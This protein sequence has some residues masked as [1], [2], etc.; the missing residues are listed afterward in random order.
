LAAGVLLLLFNLQ[1]LVAYEPTAQ[2]VVAG[3]LAV[4]G[5]G[6]LVS[7]AWRRDEW[8]RL[9]PGWTLLALA[10]M[11]LLS[12]QAQLPRPLVAAVLFVG[13]GLAFLHIYLVRR[14]EHWWAII[15]GGFMIVLAA[16]ISLSVRIARLETLGAA[17]F[18]G[19]GV[20]F[21]VLYALAGARRHW[22]AL[23]PGGVLMLFGLLIYTIDNTVQGTVLRW[24]PVALIVLGLLLVYLALTREPVQPAKFSTNVAPKG[25]MSPGRGQLGEYSGPAPGASVEVLPDPDEPQR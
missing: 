21:F 25:A 10:A 4:A 20:V 22:W 18:A 23:I 14:T 5:L 11:V 17:L 9:M 15:P 16:V 19:M 8:Y 13:L 6:F 1:V 7:Y 2:Y 24:W 3:V 12:V